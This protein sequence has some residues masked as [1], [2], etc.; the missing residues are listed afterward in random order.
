MYKSTFSSYERRISVPV[1]RNKY[2]SC[3]TKIKYLTFLRKYCFPALH[4]DPRTLLSTPRIFQGIL[5][6]V[7]P[8]QYMYIGLEKALIKILNRTPSNLIPINTLLLDFNIDGCE[9]NKKYE[10]YPI[11]VR[12]SNIPQSDAEVIGIYKGRTKP[13]DINLFLKCFITDVNDVRKK[14]LEYEDKA[15]EVHIR[16]FCL[17]L[18]ARAFI[19]RHKNHNSKKPCTKCKVKGSRYKKISV[20]SGVNH[21][22]RTDG[23]Y[24]R[25]VDAEHHKGKSPFLELEVGL[26][27]QVPIDPMHSLYLEHHKGKSPLLELKVGLV[28]QVP[29]DPMHCLY[30]DCV[31]KG[32][33][34]KQVKLSHAEILKM[35]DRIQVIVN[36]CPLEFARLS[37][38][39][40]YLE[41][42]KATQHRQFLLYFGLVATNGIVSEN[43]YI[44]YLLLSTAIRCLSLENPPITHLSFA[45]L[46]LKYFIEDAEL[47][48]DL[49]FLSYNIHNLCHLVDDVEMYGSLESYAAW[50]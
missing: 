17:D 46:P 18:V 45:R 40:K 28:T 16:L 41:D 1:F 8:G 37:E 11:Q 44:H 49:N 47:I 21:E 14:T 12:I 50:P 29:I 27:T 13:T 5:I 25:M 10:M 22:I 6:D 42:F 43:V 4:S 2:K 35:S 7:P 24:S 34:G 9:L 33:Y 36:Y 19:F 20:Y 15:L 39:L 38:T 31:D 32:T 23:E 3:G 48:Y 30:L 26:V